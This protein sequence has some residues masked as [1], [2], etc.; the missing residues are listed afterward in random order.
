[1]TVRQDVHYALRLLWKTPTFA[2]VAVLTL[3]LAIAANTV[4]FSVVN[5]VMLK[6]LPYRAP[7]QLVRIDTQ[8]PTQGFDKFWTSGPEYLALARDSRS[9]EGLAAWTLS[10][11]N[12]TGGQEPIAAEAAAVTASFAPVLGVAPALG[13]FFDEAEDAPGD[14]RAIVISDALWRRTFGADPSIVGKTVHLE[15]IPVTVVGVMPKGFDFPRAGTDVWVPLRLDPKKARPSNHYLTLTG[16]LGPGVTEAAARAELKALGDA[17]HEADPKGHTIGPKH[18]MVLASL[19]GD[20]IGPVR[21]ALLTLEAAVLFVLL[22]ACANISNLLL[23]RAEARS[24]EIAVRAALGATQARLVRQFL[25]ESMVLGLLGCGVGVAMASWGLD[26]V[27]AL[28]PEGLPRAQEIAI[29]GSVLVFALGVSLMTSLVFGLS[30]ILHARGNLGEALRGATQRAVGSGKKQLFRR[31][32]VVV[33]VGLAIVLVAGAGLMARS[34][35]RL[36]RVDVGFEPRG[37]VTLGFQLDPRTYPTDGD[38][39]ALLSRL[40]DGAA[41]LPGVRSAALVSGT[42]PSRSVDANDF[43][44]V[45]HVQAM[46]DPPLGIDYWQMMS[47]DGLTT[48]GAHLVAGR[49][50]ARTDT[51]TTEPVVL[52]NEAFARK[53]FPGESALGKR[54]VITP[55][56]TGQGNPDVVQTIVGV[57]GDIKNGGIDAKAG[58]EVFV[59]VHQTMLINHGPWEGVASARSMKL[60]VRTDGDPRALFGS[61]RAYVASVDAALPIANMQTMD[62]VVA[63]SIAKPR[64]V[65]TLLAVFAGIALLMAA[66][67]IYG[68]MAYTV[69]RRTSELGI[70]MALGASAAQ[71]KTMLVTQGLGLAGTGVIVGLAA[72]FGL[73][74]ALDR[75]LSPLLF[76]IGSLDPATY[77]VTAPLMIAVAAFACWVPARRATRIHPMAAL[78]H[79]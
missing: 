30:P 18:P 74:V 53:F 70:R 43:E 7:E 45:G 28:L 17:W 66:I 76:E 5:A 21:P 1:M 72:A 49:A 10:R 36:S 73:T 29:D 51:A 8:F 41:A 27:V 71:L 78:R 13:R 59:P 38:V 46:T 12:L 63:E 54:I 22:I 25:T 75:W 23:A 34:F 40:R 32:L 48:L 50:I 65:A 69:E 37:L 26:G 11:A 16:R 42:P 60:V 61:L 33:E 2:V 58:A 57:V 47:E 52:V 35:A 68:V 20:V 77:A 9:Y 14:P 67:G 4:V 39:D 24:G 55:G 56:S 15:A 64:F 44:I 6:P 62:R 3:G 19:K 79:E 31:A